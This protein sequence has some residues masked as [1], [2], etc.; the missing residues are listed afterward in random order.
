MA[1]IAPAIVVEGLVKSYGARR[2]VDSLSFQVCPGEIFALLGPNGAGKTTTVEILEGYRKADAGRVRVLGMDPRADGKQLHLRIGVMLQEAGLYPAITP[3]EALD[4]FARFYPR[5]RDRNDL[6]DLVGLT[7]S[8]ASHYRRL[9]GGQKQR[10]ALALALVGR[11]ELVF[12]DEP[13]A[14]L[15]PQARRATW[16]IVSALRNERVTVVLTTHYLEEAERLADRVAIVDHG[17]LVALDT[18]AALVRSDSS[19]V[20]LRTAG[21]VSLEG[22]ASLPSARNVR[23]DGNGAYTFETDDASELLAEITSWLRD[24]GV[25]ATELRVGRESL[26]DVFLHLTGMEVAP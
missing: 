14:G 26:E 12:L 18:P 11:P 23:E 17:R 7:D 9:S 15:D 5:P 4:L 21:V 2:A 25:L 19:I 16:D 1:E 8:G 24:R 3:R 13:T 22:L 10:L 6:L 20:R